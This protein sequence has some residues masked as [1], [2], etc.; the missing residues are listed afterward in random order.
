MMLL[1]VATKEFG[2]SV[3]MVII[4]KAQLRQELEPITKISAQNVETNNMYSDTITT[5][6]LFYRFHHS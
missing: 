6:E 4:M 5:I 2:G 1:K 3:Q